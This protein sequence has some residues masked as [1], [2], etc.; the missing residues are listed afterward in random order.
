MSE[1]NKEETV[2]QEQI[3]QVLSDTKDDFEILEESYE[4]QDTLSDTPDEQC[5]V[6][7]I[8]N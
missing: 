6:I 2:T 1:E 8:G 7:E 5:E 3:E 4:W